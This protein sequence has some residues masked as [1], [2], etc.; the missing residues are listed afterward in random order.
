MTGSRHLQNLVDLRLYDELLREVTLADI[1]EAWVRYHHADSHPADTYE[2]PDWWAVEL[3]QDTLTDGDAWWAREDRVRGGILAIVDAADDDDVGIIGAAIMEAF[4]SNDA[5]R[6]EWLE[7]QARVSDR[8]RRSLANVWIGGEVRSD[9]FLRVERAAGAGIP[10]PR[11]HGDR[12]T[13]NPA[14]PPESSGA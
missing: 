5:G 8:F 14:G 7:E 1:G 4:I 6:L 2:D 10:W 3:W 9:V 12:P 13:A 11:N